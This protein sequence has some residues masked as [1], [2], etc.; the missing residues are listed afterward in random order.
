MN[1]VKTILYHVYPVET[2]CDDVRAPVGVGIARAVARS[3]PAPVE[4]HSNVVLL[5]EAAR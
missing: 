1:G 5:A 4:R 2:Y 3:D